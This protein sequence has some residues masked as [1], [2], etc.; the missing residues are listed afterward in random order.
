MKPHTIR[1]SYCCINKPVTFSHCHLKLGHRFH[2]LLKA[3]SDRDDIVSLTWYHRP[4]AC[5]LMSH[6][7]I[8][9]NWQHMHSIFHLWLWGKKNGSHDTPIVRFQSCAKQVKYTVNVMVNSYF[10]CTTR[11]TDWVHTCILDNFWMNKEKLFCTS[12]MGRSVVA[13]RSSA[14]DSS[15]G[16]AKMW[17]RI[18][19][20]RGACVLEQDT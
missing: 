12:L 1:S 9:D 2:P 16:V 15:S 8:I 6:V 7:R 4:D 17:V 18:L 5:I 20:G 11:E 3:C 13:E 10:F 14:L 19:A